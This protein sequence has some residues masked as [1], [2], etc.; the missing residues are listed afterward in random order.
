MLDEKSSTW[1]ALHVMIRLRQPPFFALVGAKLAI[2]EHLK[3]IAVHQLCTAM[4][5]FKIYIRPDDHAAGRFEV[6]NITPNPTGQVN[7]L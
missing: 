3:N 7:H 4:F 2:A 5:F 6:I 1:G